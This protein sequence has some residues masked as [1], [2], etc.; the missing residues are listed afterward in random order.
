MKLPLCFALLINA[1]LANPI[2]LLPDGGD[3]TSIV[4]ANSINSTG[5][6]VGACGPFDTVPC[7]WDTSETP[8]SYTPPGFTNSELVLSA[9]DLP[10]VPCSVASS[11]AADIDDTGLVLGFAFSLEP[12]PICTTPNYTGTLPAFSVW[13]QF[14]TFRNRPPGSQPFFRS[15]LYSCEERCPALTEYRNSKASRRKC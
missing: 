6:I 15:P 13:T 5:I 8:P 11:E 7:Y 9:H 12:F 3:L 1:A 2:F 4:I 14:R 10:S